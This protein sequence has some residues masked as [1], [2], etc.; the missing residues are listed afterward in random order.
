[1]CS[2]FIVIGEC[3]YCDETLIED[4]K[5]FN[6]ADLPDVL[7]CTSCEPVHALRLAS[8]AR[9]DTPQVTK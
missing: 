7:V 8:V 6:V 4:R 3:F 9:S 2:S 1:M 5:D